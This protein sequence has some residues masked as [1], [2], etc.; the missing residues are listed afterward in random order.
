MSQALF[1]RLVAKPPVLHQQKDGRPVSWGLS[2]EV[3]RGL[4]GK[5][6]PGMRT[7]ET[8]AG[9]S[10]LTFMV[11]GCDHV[12]VS[13]SAAERDRIL[14][15][16]EEVGATGHLRYVAESSDTALPELATEITHL[17]VVLIDGAHRFPFPML[18]FHY[19]EALV[20]VGGWMVVDDV[21]IPS[22]AMLYQFLEAE[23]Q[24]EKKCH[25]Q[26]TVFYERV[27]ETVH[28]GDWV[29]QKLN[30]PEERQ[31]FSFKRLYKKLLG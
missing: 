18:D 4:Y 15:W 14:V 23:D 31:L 13:P 26:N 11:A 22:V 27:A 7:L 17:D 19:T 16:N 21:H 5:L 30:R 12:A 8:G 1:D 29:S 3:L 24:W 9:L 25:I 6:R 10:T 2:T 20:P 28:I